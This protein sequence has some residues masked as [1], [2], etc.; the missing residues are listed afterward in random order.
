MKQTR[1]RKK[2]KLYN[3]KAMAILFIGFLM[4]FCLV[5]VL[6]RDKEFSEKENRMLEQKPKLSWTGIESGRY[7][8]QYESYKSDQFA[9]RNFWVAFKTRVDLIAGRRESN[10]VFKGDKKYLLED[11]AKPNQE[12]M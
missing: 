2:G 6:V 1:Q 5:N 4:L 12:Q 8:K 9:G 11:I 7:M 3:R 10:G